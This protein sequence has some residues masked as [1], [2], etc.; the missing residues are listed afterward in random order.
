[1][2]T[3]LES[4]LVLLD[5]ETVVYELEDAGSGGGKGTNK[6]PRTSRTMKAR[7]GTVEENETGR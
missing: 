1:L 6:Q 7:S 2:P 4:S 5:A 3:R